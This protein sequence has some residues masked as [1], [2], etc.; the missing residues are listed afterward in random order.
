MSGLDLG[1]PATIYDFQA[2]Y[3][4][5]IAVG[6][7][8]RDDKRGFTKWTADYA[9]HDRP[10]KRDRLLREWGSLNS[11]FRLKFFESSRKS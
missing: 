1:A 8:D 4:T 3:C 2:G 7:F 6:F 5:C 10:L 9:L 11:L